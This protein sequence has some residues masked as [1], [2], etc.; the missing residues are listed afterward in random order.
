MIANLKSK[1]KFCYY[2]KTGTPLNFYLII[3]AARAIQMSVTAY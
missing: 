1:P 3:H 2:D